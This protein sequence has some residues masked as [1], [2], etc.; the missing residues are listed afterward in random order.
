MAQASNF[1][2][3]YKLLEY[4]IAQ[5]V[6]KKIAHN[7]ISHCKALKADVNLA[8]SIWKISGE[9]LTLK[10]TSL[11]HLWNKCAAFSD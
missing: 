6:A 2:L 1:A 5:A 9:N 7:S 4:Q 10:R 8:R 3:Q 11:I